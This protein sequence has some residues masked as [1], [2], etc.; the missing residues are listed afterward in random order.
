MASRS[1]HAEEERYCWEMLLCPNGSGRG[2][3]Q[4]PGGGSFCSPQAFTRLSFGGHQSR[5]LLL[6][7]RGTGAHHTA[8]GHVRVTQDPQGL[9]RLPLLDGLVDGSRAQ[10]HCG[11]KGGSREPFLTSPLQQHPG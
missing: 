10:S 2:A 1:L 3:P 8:Q 6:V 11:S 4:A 9:R 5:K 7:R